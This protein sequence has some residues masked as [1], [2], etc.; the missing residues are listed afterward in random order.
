MSNSPEEP[1][2]KGSVG[3]DRAKGTLSRVGSDL[4][5]RVVSGIVM[6]VVALGL[7]VADTTSFALLVLAIALV[8][9]WEWGRMV[10]GTDADIVLSAHLGGVA[11]SILLAAIGLPALG[12]LALAMSTILVA[13]LAFGRASMLSALGVACAGLPGVSLL[14]VRAD[15]NTGL[16]AVLYIL[17]SVVVTDVGA[18]FSGRLIGGPKIWPRISPNKT[19]AGLF[20]AM[21]AAAASGWMFGSFCPVPAS[22]EKLAIG[23]VIIAI[24][25]QVGDFA[26]SALKRR[27][28]TKDASS[29]IPGHGGFMDRVDGLTAAAIAV[30]LYAVINSPMA[31]ARAILT[32]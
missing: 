20:G 24:V 32:W 26:E 19:W 25:A 4:W 31:P 13:L 30:G 15:G 8:V 22:P 10:R 23:G 1:N 7:T 28:G 2:L 6:A 18:Y 29:L 3:D 12:I 5:P 27:F 16:W 9:S 14:W 21:T 11:A 17:L